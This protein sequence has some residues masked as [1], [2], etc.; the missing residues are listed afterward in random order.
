MRKLIISLLLAV[1]LA[2]TGCM[3]MEMATEF[4]KDGSGIFRFVMSMSTEVEEALDELSNMEGAGMDGEMEE[5]PDFA[6]FDKKDLEKKL[7]KYDAKFKSYS[8][9]V[10]NGKRTVSMEI[11]FG[12]LRGLHAA[13]A[14]TMDD[15]EE[16]V[17]IEKQ[18]DG[19]YL[20][21]TA[22]N[23]VVFEEEVAAEP[24]EPA[25]E[26]SMEDMQAAMANAGKSM[27][28]MGKLMAHSSELAVIMEI[29]VP[30]DVIE[31]NAPVLDGRTCRWEINSQNMMQMESFDPRIRFEGK[32]VNIK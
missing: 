31:H 27:E 26:P 13:M 17:A 1:T 14:L 9:K 12:D 11:A 5:M 25:K 21:H 2:A 32:G 7:S 30:G 23:L 18:E 8:N 29:T 6:N 19:S 16:G 15:S 3:Q 22:E 4:A 24:E 20:L 28:L 10:E